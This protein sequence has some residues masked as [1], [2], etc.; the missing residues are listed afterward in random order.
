M[1]VFVLQ[2]P[3]QKRDIHAVAKLERVANIVS[4]VRDQHRAILLLVHTYITFTFTKLQNI[5][6]QRDVID[7]FSLF[8]QNS[9][10]ISY[11]L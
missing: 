1:A 5:P 10:L 11:S 7:E 8:F 3:I 2:I 6:N 9:A 4:K